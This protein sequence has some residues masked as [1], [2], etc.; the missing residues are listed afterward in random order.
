MTP[1]Q[2]LITLLEQAERDRDAAL[3]EHQQALRQHQSAIEQAAHLQQYR[4]DHSR[5]WQHRFGQQGAIEIVHCYQGF[6]E[7]LNQ[8]VSY[9]DHMV[10]HAQARVEHCK[11]LLL[12]QEMRVASVRKLIER[13]QGEARL[14]QDRREQKAADEFAT[15]VA[16]SRSVA[17]NV[18]QY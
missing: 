8:A 12:E 3:A 15:R 14:A 13:R 5:R 18:S 9:Q 10:E 7:R 1:L 4:D 6:T 16:W 17:M 2:P 11:T